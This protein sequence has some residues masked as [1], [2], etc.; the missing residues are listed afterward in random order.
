MGT[1]LVWRDGGTLD[2]SK[3]LTFLVKTRNLFSV[4][5]HP[6]EEGVNNVASSLQPISRMNNWLDSQIHYYS[7]IH[8]VD[9]IKQDGFWKVL[10]SGTMSAIQISYVTELLIISMFQNMY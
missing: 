3:L 9:H 10:G 1:F 7:Y 4:A 8:I 6:L 5:T 2:F